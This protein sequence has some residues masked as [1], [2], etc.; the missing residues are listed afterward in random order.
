MDAR[1]K[2]IAKC[3]KY[4]S[5]SWIKKYIEKKANKKQLEDGI[6]RYKK[7]KI[8]KEEVIEVLDKIDFNHDIMLHTSMLNL[9]HIS[10]GTKFV[11]DELLSRM[12]ATDHTLLVSALPYFGAF[13]DYLHEGMIFDTR[14]APV[15]MGEINSR[16]SK[17]PEA[18]RSC[19]PTHSVVAVGKDAHYYTSTHHFDITPFGKGSPYY[20]I[21]KNRGKI[22]L[23]G[24][25]MNNLTMVHAIEDALGDKHPVK[26]I[27]SKKIFNIDCITQTG[28]PVTVVTPYHNTWRS[29]FRRDI[30]LE[31][32]LSKGYISRFKLGDGY[33]IVVD[34]YLYAVNYLK[35]MKQGQDQHG[36]CKPLP[37]EINIDFN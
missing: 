15:A 32:G 8:K 21:I 28:E 29:I 24:A 12:K 26:D 6:L 31:D 34:A 20:K 35:K 19:H 33:V 9:G 17:L 36:K 37:N 14:T 25:T 1:L 27:Y 2:R 16:I 10:G 3:I 23:F 7:F 22:L 4:F 18:L 11:T 5:P 30:M 13:A